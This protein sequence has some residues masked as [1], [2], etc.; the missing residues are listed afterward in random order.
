[1]EKYYLTGNEFVS[2]PA[3]REDASIESINFLH[4]GYRGLIEICGSPIIKPL[5]IIDSV[6]RK[7]EGIEWEYKDYWMPGFIGYIDNLKIKGTICAPLGCRGF[8]YNI[9][10]ENNGS[11]VQIRTG[12]EGTWDKAVHSINE[13]KVI[14]GN[15]HVYYSNWNRG[16]MFDFRN[17]ITLFS[18]GYICS[19][20]PDNKK[21]GYNKLETRDICFGGDEPVQYEISKSM[22]IEKGEKIEI[23]FYLGLGLEEVG[24]AAS[25]IEM[26][27]F[28][29]RHLIDKTK[30]WLKSRVKTTGDYSLDRLF[31]LNLFFNY[32]YA[33]GRTIDTE[34]M[35]LVTSRSPRYYV[36][37][38]YW[39]RDS[40][41]WSF[42]SLLLVDKNSAREALYYVFEKQIKN[43][44]IHS[45]YIDGTVLEPGFELDELCAP[46]IAIDKYI[47]Y[48]GDSQIIYEEPVKKGIYKILGI[49]DTKK[50][51]SEELYETFLM[52]TDD[53]RLYPYLTY[54]NVLVWKTFKIASEFL[55]K[56][57]DSKSSMR[58]EKLSKGIRESILKNCIVEKNGKNIFAWAVD[59]E[60]KSTVYD[61]PPGSLTL[62]PYYGFCSFDDEVYKNTVEYLYSDEFEHYFSK[63]NFKELGCSHANHPWI[64]SIANS[65]LNGR[66]SKAVE[67]LKKAAMDNGIACESIDENTGECITGAHFATCAGFLCYAIY[68]T[69]IKNKTNRS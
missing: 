34:E 30:R 16:P 41:L 54:N 15:K 31:N 37:A 51:E 64:L 55:N 42:P 3:I 5:F 59:L 14:G 12:L 60:G 66:H 29:Y 44:G 4:M 8:I 13:S 69:C 38:A 46:I 24:A 21:W 26:Q 20:E 57:G 39:D 11:D 65:L 61:E 58:Y 32:F 27:R 22:N 6:E 47:D 7:M 48:T 52:P 53:M 43:I 36:S 10:I 40:L 18:F 50:H 35:V 45:R 49:I 1:M 68:L 23:T 63:G 17:G 2:I 25:A 19:F 62:L 33:S 9:E 28:G 67:M 56:L